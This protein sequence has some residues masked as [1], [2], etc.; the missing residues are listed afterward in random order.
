MKKMGDTGYKY[1]FYSTSPGTRS[2]IQFIQESELSCRYST[3]KLSL[4]YEVP[5]KN[6]PEVGYFSCLIMSQ[7]MITTYIRHAIVSTQ[8]HGFREYSYNAIGKPTTMT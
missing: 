5:D 6:D 3:T 1:T 7:N 8:D 4:V 2:Y